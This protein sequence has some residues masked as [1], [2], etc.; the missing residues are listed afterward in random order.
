MVGGGL[1]GGVRHR[2]D[3]VRRDQ[4]VDI[5]RVGVVGVLHPGGGPQRALCVGAVVGE[6]LPAGRAEDLL[7]GL[8]GQSGVG[9]PGL[10]AQRQSVIGADR[11]QLLVDLAVHP[12]DEERGHR[13]DLGQVVPGLTR[14]LE[15]GEEGV[16]DAAIAVQREDQRHVDADALG[17]HLADGRQPLEGG[18]DLDEQVGTVDRLPELL[19]HGD[20]ALGVVLQA[21]VDLDGD[22]AVHPVGG[23]VDRPQDVAGVAD[24]LGGELE[25]GLVHVGPGPHQLGDLVGVGLAVGQGVGEDRRVG[26]DTDHVA[27]VDQLLQL[28]AADHLA[29]EVVQPDGDP[30]GGQVGERGA[31]GHRDHF[32]WVDAGT[33]PM[34]R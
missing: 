18:R 20:G 6:V 12:G 16:H 9:Q 27:G 30:G 17:Q 1:H 34:V 28:T 26:G 32:S 4:A 19:G 11:V 10:A 7:V 33:S 3:G 14:L 5:H 23:V 24:V 8:V 29:V 2:V 22:P 13:V 21:R 25:D 31:V 15:A